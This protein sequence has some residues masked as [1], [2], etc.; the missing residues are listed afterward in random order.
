ME[1]TC[2]SSSSSS[3][4][5]PSPSSSSSP[6]SSPSSPSSPSP[7]PS[8]KTWL[9]ESYNLQSKSIWPGRGQHILA[10]FDDETIIV[11]QAYRQEI[12]EYASKHNKFLGCP[13]FSPTRMT[14]VKTNFLWMMFRSDWAS[15]PNQTNI[16]AIWLKKEAFEKY[17][18][19]AKT[20]GSVRGFKGTVRLQW[21]PDHFP[22]GNKHPYRR[23]VQ[24]GLK[25]VEGFASG[26]DIVWIEDVTDFVREQGS[27]VRDGGWMGKKK[28]K[29]E[30]KG[31][32]KEEK[33]KEKDRELL[34]ARERVFV[35]K[36]RVA[37]EALDLSECDKDGNVVKVT[38]NQERE[39]RKGSE[40]KKTIK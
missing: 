5:P 32:G 33:E 26:E 16:L 14:W 34:V 1:G 37:R 9:S 30:K 29:R 18:E 19:N 36:S 22:S 28:E 12:A 35:P 8:P 2:T 24:L 27:L 6:S 15:K 10:Q 39:E 38:G 25:G 17:L 3:F 20:R 13:L 11:Y 4:S 31:K 21:D 40:I 23:A 7:S